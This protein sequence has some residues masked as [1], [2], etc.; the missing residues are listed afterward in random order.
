MHPLQAGVARVSYILEDAGPA[1]VPCGGH[2]VA[3]PLC[4]PELCG[5]PRESWCFLCTQVLGPVA[6]SLRDLG[7]QAPVREG[8]DASL[9]GICPVHSLPSSSLHSILSFSF[10]F[11]HSCPRIPP[12]S[13]FCP[14]PEHV[15]ECP[16]RATFPCWRKLKQE[17]HV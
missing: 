13:L 7:S 17:W 16:V 5:E 9:T 14:L 8:E 11:L 10:S 6:T 12:P 3:G 2:V 1:E 15:G 4:H